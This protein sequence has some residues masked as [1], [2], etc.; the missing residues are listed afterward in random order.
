MAYL[1]S[2]CRA[3]ME[4]AEIPRSVRDRANSFSGGMLQRILLAREFSEDASLVVLS[5]A[6]SG[7]DEI[8]RRKFS[9]ELQ[10]LVQAGTS[11][12]LFSTDIEELISVADE[13]MEL[14]NGTLVNL[15]GGRNEN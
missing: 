4:R 5:E 14:K 12:L 3:I 1:D 2:W 15:T 13:I 7:L 10:S 11:A 9:G 6:G 8:N